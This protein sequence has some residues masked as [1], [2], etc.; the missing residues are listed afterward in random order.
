M[1]ESN[2]S[3][4]TRCL[5]VF[6]KLFIKYVHRFE[7][8][9][10]RIRDDDEDYLDYVDEFDNIFREIVFDDELD[11]R[12]SDADVSKEIIKLSFIKYLVLILHVLHRVCDDGR[13][14]DRNEIFSAFRKWSWFP[15]REIFG[16]KYVYEVPCI[17]NDDEEY[18][19]YEEYKDMKNNYSDI[20]QTCIQKIINETIAQLENGEFKYMRTRAYVE[21]LSE[22]RN[23][24]STIINRDLG[25]VEHAINNQIAFP[26]DTYFEMFGNGN[27]NNSAFRT[28]L[29]LLRK[30][31]NLSN[32]NITQS[33]R[34]IVTY[35]LISWLLTLLV[36]Q[37][38]EIIVPLL[39]VYVQR[40]LRNWHFDP[41]VP[42]LYSALPILYGRIRYVRA[43]EESHR[44]ILYDQSVSTVREHVPP[45]D[46]ITYECPICREHILTQIAKILT[47]GHVFHERCLRIWSKTSAACPMCRSHIQFAQ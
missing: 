31:V 11:N 40:L 24:Y 16:L 19:E 45:E 3:F 7:Q 29:T 28:G 27:D 30:D 32:S 10:L 21:T 36:H 23:V 37:D 13:I 25:I 46:L 47:C 33:I 18:E 42:E 39:F 1:A 15:R 17:R 26:Y 5:R 4:V 9:S 6:Y 20:E 8:P 38:R 12:V 44:A 41:E 14:T 43:N 2:T 35:K 22:V 34:T